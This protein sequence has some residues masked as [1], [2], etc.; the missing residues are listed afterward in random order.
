MD[1]ETYYKNKNKKAENGGRAF[2]NQAKK[3]TRK[4]FGPNV[5]KEGGNP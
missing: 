5:G 1:E 3:R 2:S 4:D